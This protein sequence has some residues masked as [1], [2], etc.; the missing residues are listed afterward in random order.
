MTWW[1]IVL[2]ILASISGGLLIGGLLTYL[3][4]RF[5][6]RPLLERLFL[7]KRETTVVV[8]EPLKSITPDLLAELT[9]KRETTAV[10]EESLKPI[11]PDLLAG[12]IKKRETLEQQAKEQAKREA[13]AAKKARQAEKQQRKEAEQQAKEQAKREVEAAKKSREAEKQQ[14]KEAEQ[15]AKEQAKREVE[16]A[17]MTTEAGE[18]EGKGSEVVGAPVKPK[19]PNLAAEVENNRQ[20]AT[21]PWTGK[22]LPFE[23]GVWDTSRDG[24]PTLPANL[25]EDLTQAYVD[26]RLANSIVWLATEL[27]RRSQNLDDNYMKLCTNITTRLD[28]ILP[29]LKQSGK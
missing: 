1:Q 10:T 27:G 11:T 18:R 8:D 7:K 2:I 20:I 29:L 26:M 5:L 25:G 16:L 9:N 24:V 23:T 17:R 22:L 21:Q 19:P 3:A 14:I 13:E 6:K 15:Q 28:K 12:L 4:A